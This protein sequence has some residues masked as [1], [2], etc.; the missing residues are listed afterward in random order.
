M[1]LLFR[2]SYKIRTARVTA[3]R[4]GN[5]KIASKNMF[6]EAGPHGGVFRNGPFYRGVGLDTLSTATWS[7]RYEARIT[8]GVITLSLSLRRPLLQ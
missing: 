3:N 7:S 6:R 1:R 4:T 2:G 8:R 5:T